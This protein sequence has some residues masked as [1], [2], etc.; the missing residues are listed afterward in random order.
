MNR[1]RKIANLSY[2]DCVI[3]TE[4]IVCA[5]PVELGLRWSGFD[6]L[7]KRLG[8]TRRS[9][10][11]Q[12][13]VVDGER[14]ARLVEAVSRCYPFNPTCL[15]KSLVLLWILRKRGLPAELRIG[16]R[17]VGGALQAH[18]WIECGGR[19]LLDGDI[20]QQFAPMPL[21]I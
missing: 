7:V 4:A 16:V 13:A 14:A 20:D 11:R 8:R 6:T 10:G 5:I 1:L 21:N 2:A 9:R 3:L 19:T 17:K 18:A 15:K 12:E